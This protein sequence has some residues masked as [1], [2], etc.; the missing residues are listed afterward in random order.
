MIPN[1]FDASKVKIDALRLIIN[2][3]LILPVIAL[4]NG[5]GQIGKSTFLYHFANRILRIKTGNPKAIW[6][7]KTYCARSAKQFV[8]IYDK[9]DNQ[10]IA[11]EEAGELLNFAEWWSVMNLVFGA[12]SR[13]QGYKRNICLLITP[14]ANDIAKQQKRKIDF[15]LWVAKKDLVFKTAVVVPRWVKINYLTLKEEN[16]RL[17][18]IKSWF[19][20]YGVSELRNANLYTEWLK[21]FKSDIMTDIKEKV[22]LINHTSLPEK[23]KEN[24]DFPVNIDFSRKPMW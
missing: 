10:I 19:V 5:H 16:Y 22:G 18:Y 21:E 9:S 4:I 17:R 24:Y 7:Y 23:H 12:I 8:E 6:D 15:I 11:L 1:R 20:H 2:R 3:S 14:H 13:T